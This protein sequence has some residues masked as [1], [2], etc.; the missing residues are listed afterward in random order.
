[1]RILVSLLGLMV[2]AGVVIGAAGTINP[3]ALFAAGD[4][5]AAIILQEMRLPRTVAALLAGGSLGT[6]GAVIQ[7]LTR[8]PLAEPGL[9]GINAGAALALVGTVWWLGPLTGVAMVLPALAGSLTV[10]GLILLLTLRVGTGV[11]LVLGGAALAGIAAALLRA[12]ILLDPF[13]LDA[14]RDW[15]VGSVAAVSSQA[16]L[17]GGV[18]VLGGAVLTTVTARRVDALS[19]GEDAAR[20]LGTSVA[21]SRVMALGAVALLS[22]GAVIVAGPLIFVGLVAPQLARPLSDGSAG[23]LTLASALCGASLVLGADILGRIAI[24]GLVIPVGLGVA[25]IG[26]PMAV[27][28]VARRLDA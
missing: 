15:I 23:P 22:A 26:G 18:L 6:A 20:A 16:L 13:A 12:M 25:L 10:A 5:A 21:R 17:A 2:F 1:M 3:S 8:N 24:P 4:S 7:L 14:W 28:Q 9:L 11:G 27:W 19:M